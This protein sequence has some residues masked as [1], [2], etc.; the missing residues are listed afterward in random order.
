MAKGA[1]H[2]ED[3]LSHFAN[4][5]LDEAI[6]AY[7]EALRTEPDHPDYHLNLAAAYARSNNFAEAVRAIADFLRTDSDSHLAD[8]YEQVFASGLDPVET[9]LIEGM[10]ALDLAIP[11]VGKAIQMWLE[12]RITIGRRHLRIPKPALWAGA[13]AYTT[14]KINFLPPTLA[15]V[16]AAFEVNERSLKRKFDDLVA[17]LD[18]MPAD[19]RYFAGEQN[20]LDK[21]VEAAQMMEELDRRFRS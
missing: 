4:W 15:E 18:L 19:Y 9:S 13:L 5:E 7:Q 10:R 16:A 2:N 17:T 21:L 8:R 11:H 6:A 20:P 1:K 3:G 12:F 14:V